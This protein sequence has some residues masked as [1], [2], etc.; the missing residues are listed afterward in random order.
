MAST[1]AIQR[2]RLVIRKVILG[3]A[4]AILVVANLIQ[5]VMLVDLRKQQ[6][7]YGFE[8]PLI[9]QSIRL[10]SSRLGVSENDAMNNRFAVTSYSGDGG[11]V[12]LRLERDMIGS[13][14]FFCYDQD[15]RLTGTG[16][17]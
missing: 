8:K 11:C 15:G 3:V 6:P 5:Y 12:T 1:I 16:E 2:R 14:P 13:T 9:D 4:M 10:Y 17:R 7:Y